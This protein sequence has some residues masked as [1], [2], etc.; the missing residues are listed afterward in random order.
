MNKVLK[1]LGFC[2]LGL[3]SFG[4][5]VAAPIVHQHFGR[6]TLLKAV[7]IPAF[8]LL[9][10][11][12]NSIIYFILNVPATISSGEKL[13]YVKVVRINIIYLGTGYNEERFN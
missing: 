11:F 1:T 3:L 12:R 4:A 8:R 7:E 2:R 5:F 9:I 10:C 6:Y 13:G